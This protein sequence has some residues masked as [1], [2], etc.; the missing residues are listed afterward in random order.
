MRRKLFLI[1]SWLLLAAPA[2]AQ[3]T[4]IFT[5]EATTGVETVTPVLTW[6]TIP[7]ADDCTASGDWSG[8]KGGAGME[9][10]PPI[11][12][13]ATYNLQCE[14]LDVTV[15][16]TW[17]APT[18]NTDGTPLVD[19]AGFKVYYGQIQGGPYDNVIDLVD[20]SATTHVI[21]SLTSGNWFLVATAYNGIG[22]ESL[23][24]NEAMKNL[25]LIGVT[26]SIGITVNARPAPPSGLTVE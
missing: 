12:T 10:L 22:T 16:L 25:G 21:T 2:L 9:T 11:S 8:A 1:Y 17:I 3:N 14:W 19:L 4:I 26:D 13:G 18:Q 20:P 7:L 23:L 5:A 15:T 24:S 6:D